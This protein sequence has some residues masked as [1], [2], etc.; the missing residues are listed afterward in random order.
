MEFKFKS[1]IK[2]KFFIAF[3]LCAVVAE[4]QADT[5]ASRWAKVTAPTLEKAQSIGDYTAGCV[6]GAVSL[7]QNGT[8]YQIMRLSRQRFYGHPTLTQFIENL[9][10]STYTQHLGTLL[11]G[12]LGQP[13]GGPTLSGHRSHQSGLD[14]DIWF[15]L[16]PQADQRTLTAIERE[17]WGASSVLL[18]KSDDMDFTQWTIQNEKVLEIAAR[19]PEVDRIFVNPSVKRQLCNNTEN[20]D[21]LRKIR[22]WWRHDDHFHVRLKCPTD[23]K[24]CQSQEPLPAGDGCDTKLAW[25]FTAD[26]KKP[27]KLPLKPAAEV[28]LPALC[29]TVLNLN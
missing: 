19:M 25:W 23:S 2:Q 22:P 12:D 10:Q 17:K 24:N 5:V 6:S 4:C 16:S 18:A 29:N 8:G 7:P 15:L 11:I 14:V 13:R 9:A 27:A 21:W 3:L 1:S 28:K 20:H 26:A